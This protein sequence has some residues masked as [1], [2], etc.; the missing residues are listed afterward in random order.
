[1]GRGP[2]LRRTRRAAPRTT[3][4]WKRELQAIF[5]R[6]SRDVWLRMLEEHDV[7]STPVN[8]LEDMFNDPQ[9]RQYGFP[10]E[11]EHPKMGKMKLVGSG[12]N[13]SRTPPETPTPPPMLGE[14]TD[15]I[16]QGLGYGA[17]AIEGLRSRRVI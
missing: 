9:V 13:M 8:N 1:M 14:N 15:E 17:E 5:G 2:S 4:C 10:I 3:T 16:L 7:P 6:D 12:V 11:V